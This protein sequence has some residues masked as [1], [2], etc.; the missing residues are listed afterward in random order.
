MFSYELQGQTTNAPTEHH[1]QHALSP[2]I[3]NQL[4]AAGCTVEEGVAREYRNKSELQDFGEHWT[5][6]R[7]RER[8]LE[9]W[10]L[11]FVA[12]ALAMEGSSFLSLP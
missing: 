7:H 4:T 9:Q 5:R 2:T 12:E 6:L 3:Q 11:G 1:H 10:L 8:K